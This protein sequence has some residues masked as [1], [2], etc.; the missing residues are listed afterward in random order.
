[1][2]GNTETRIYSP[3][4]AALGQKPQQLELTMHRAPVRLVGNTTIAN[5]YR[6]Q[7]PFKVQIPLHLGPSFQG[8]R[9]DGSWLQRLWQVKAVLAVGGRP[10]LSYTAEINVAAMPP[11]PPAVSSSSVAGVTGSIQQGPLTPPTS[12]K[13][14]ELPPTNCQ[15][16]GA[17]FTLTQ[18]DFFI[19]CTYCGNSIIIGTQEQ[20]RKHS[21]IENHLFMQQVA[22]A[23]LNY[24]DKGL[25][26]VGVSKEAVITNATLRYLPFWI[27]TVNATTSFM[28]IEDSSLGGEFRQ[29][30]GTIQDKKAS[31]ASKLGSIILAGTEAYMQSQ[32]K[33]HPAPRSV[34]QTFSNRYI[35]PILARQAMVSEISFYDV[36]VQHKMPFDPAKLPPNAEFLKSELSEADAQQQ[37]RVE[38]EAKARQI[39][40]GKVDKLQSISTNVVVG[41]GELIHSPIWFVYYALKGEN[42][43]ILVDGSE[44]KVLGGGRPSIK[45][46]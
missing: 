42:Y 6:Q 37:A 43:A 21:M 5:G 3:V 9:Q 31:T 28:G 14:A 1:L 19:T 34:A 41:E 8:A 39:V 27:F 32:N 26:R 12:S 29:V 18:E 24:M 2:A 44:G 36:P 17:P 40:L 23:A 22:E 4:N 45:L 30:Q 25:L 38:V 16:C 10:D 7:M 33:Y 35:W 11:P 20:L 13:P 46:G 15:K